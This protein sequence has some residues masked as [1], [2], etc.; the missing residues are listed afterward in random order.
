MRGNVHQLYARSRSGGGECRVYRLQLPQHRRAGDPPGGGDR[1]PGC[2][3]I[4]RGDLKDRAVGG[5]PVRDEPR[6]RSGVDR[7]ALG[8]R[9][10]QPLADPGIHADLHCGFGGTE[11]LPFLP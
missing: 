9:G 8:G 7:A 6:G 5:S 1:E 4:G 3:S 2:L 11:Y 10:I